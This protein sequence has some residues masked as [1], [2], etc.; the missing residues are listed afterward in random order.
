[1]S[2]NWL[3]WILIILS[4]RFNN[5]IVNFKKYNSVCMHAYL[6]LA[7]VAERILPAAAAANIQ[8][9]S[10]VHTLFIPMT[11]MSTTALQKISH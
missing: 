1:M 2:Y 10:T 11:H 7:T 6:W 4:R 8:H 9:Y 3:H 5:K